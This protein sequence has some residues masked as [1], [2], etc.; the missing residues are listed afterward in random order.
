MGSNPGVLEVERAGRS[1]G[2]GMGV[3]QQQ[4]QRVQR[5]WP[6]RVRET[7]DSFE[8]ERLLFV[9]QRVRQH[10]GIARAGCMPAGRPC[11]RQDLRLSGAGVQGAL[12]IEFCEQTV[13][14]KA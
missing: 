7:D 3:V 2:C 14:Q 5:A 1:A 9:P 11:R 13:E 12:G 4:G 8:G 10:A 6:T